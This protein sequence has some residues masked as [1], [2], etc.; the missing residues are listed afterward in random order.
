MTTQTEKRLPWSELEPSKS[1][2]MELADRLCERIRSKRLTPGTRLG[3]E[4]ELAEEFGVSRTVVREAIG[5]L[6]G[7]KV[8]TGRQRLG[9]FVAGGDVPAVLDKAILPQASEEVGGLQLRQFRVVIELGSM[10]MAVEN[11]TPEQ[12]ERLKS[13]AAEMRRQMKSFASDPNAT[14]KAVDLLDRQFHETVLEAAGVEIV[15]QFH[16]VLVD[17]FQHG[18][19]ASEPTLGLVR[20]HERIAKA[21]AARDTGAAVQE[22]TKHLRP[23]Y[24]KKK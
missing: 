14:T 11:A 8:V 19:F 2:S 12:I 21:I 3:T 9:L 24:R 22:L 13:L 15:S 17:Y 16:D 23:L 7:L 1:L 20:E 10:P 4:A 5:C 6:R 18:N